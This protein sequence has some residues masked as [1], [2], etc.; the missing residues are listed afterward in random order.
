LKLTALIA[1]EPT[2]KMDSET[3][4][5]SSR[6]VSDPELPSVLSAEKATDLIRLCRQGKLHDVEAW[7]KARTSLSVPADF[8][9]SPLEEA[10]ETGFHSLVHLLARNE[11]QQQVKNK[12][13]QKATELRRFELVEVLVD[14]GARVPEIPF[15]CALRTRD[16]RIIQFYLD[17]GANVVAE[18]PFAE[19]FCER[20][21][22][23]LRPFINHRNTHPELAQH[24]QEQL[25]SALR[26]FCHEGDSKWVSLLMSAG[27]DPR[28]REPRHG[29]AD[30]PECYETALQIASS[31]E[32]VEVLKRLRPNR[33]ADDLDDLLV[34]ASIFP[35]NEII[36]YLLERGANPNKKENGASEALD[37]C[38]WNIHFKTLSRRDSGL[39]L[40][41]F[42]F[43]GVFDCIRLLARKGAIW[44]PEDSRHMNRVRKTFYECDPD[45]IIDWLKIIKETEC[46]TPDTLHSFLST[47]SMKE[48]L[49]NKK[50]W[51]AHLKMKDLLFPKPRLP[52]LAKMSRGRGPIRSPSV[53][54]QLRTRFNRADLY[55]K[56]WEMPVSTV[57][58]EFGISDVALAKT[59]KKLFIPLPGRGYWA[60]RT[61]GKNVGPRPELR[62]LILAPR[63]GNGGRPPSVETTR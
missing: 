3:R 12:A 55:R 37:R 36:A 47:P 8:K 40:S 5:N 46:A 33:E 45:V 27:A 34:C 44:K 13:L 1:G 15:L 63:S 39:G 25:N 58:K 50:W 22:T 28:S 59:C 31:G 19:A 53:S 35:R 57:A 17:H 2:L 30:D 11:E 32:S 4:V 48:H 9:N 18:H 52:D 26:H 21:R 16:P 42:S 54:L 62:S 7:I 14:E 51:L 61:A 43:Y 20:I 41:A 38:L 23:V 29:D 49:A 56:V 10:V 6:P 60:Q 24:L